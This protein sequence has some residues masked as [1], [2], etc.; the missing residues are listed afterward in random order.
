MKGE[1]TTDHEPCRAKFVKRL[2]G[3][4]PPGYLDELV[5]YTGGKESMLGGPLSAAAEFVYSL[6][7]G[8]MAVVAKVEAV[9]MSEWYAGCWTGFFHADGKL[10]DTLALTHRIVA[11]G[12]S[13]DVG[14]ELV[15]GCPQRGPGREG[16]LLAGPHRVQAAGAI[17]TPF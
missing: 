16:Y 1:R 7:A 17:S 11:L 6:D 5:S 13:M 10:G 9:R 3:P 2:R 8:E 14:A 12:G 4:S 15:A